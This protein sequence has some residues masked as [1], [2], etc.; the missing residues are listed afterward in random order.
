MSCMNPLP[1]YGVGMS[2]REIEW[3]PDASEVRSYYDHMGR[4][5]DILSFY[6]LPA[7]DDLMTNADFDLAQNIF[8]LG[9][10]TGRFAERLFEKYLPPEARYLGCDASEVMVGLAQSRLAAHA[11]RAQIVPA[12]DT[13]RLPLLDKEADRIVSI[14]VLDLLGEEQV[15]QFFNEAYRSLSDDGKLCFLSL[16]RGANIPSRIVSALWSALFAKRPMLLGGCRPIDLDP[17]VDRHRWQVMHRRVMAPFLVPAEV[18]IL[19]KRHA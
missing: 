17:F 6:G 19:E 9:C 11:K 15:A 16:H 4:K 5:L 3:V 14:F 13:M 1:A 10:G 7:V 12:D 8:E 18:W 2:D